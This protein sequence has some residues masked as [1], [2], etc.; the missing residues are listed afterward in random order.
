M[1]QTKS[2]W[3]TTNWSVFSILTLILLADIFSP[4][5]ITFGGGLGDLM[6]W[7]II[8][9][10]LLLQLILILVFRNKTNRL[11]ALAII[12]ILFAT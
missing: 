3:K 6:I 5:T 1:F 2:F 11:C 12:Y 10:A 9:I 7:G 4:I 8:V